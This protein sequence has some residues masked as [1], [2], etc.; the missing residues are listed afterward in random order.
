MTRGQNSLE[1]EFD[2]PVVNT[3]SKQVQRVPLVVLAATDDELTEHERVLAEI[4]KESK[5]KCLW[6][7]LEAQAVPTA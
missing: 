2:A 4:A 3:R 5:G 6:Q 7:A 1:M